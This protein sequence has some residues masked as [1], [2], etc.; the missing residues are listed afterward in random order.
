MKEK[1]VEITEET[2]SFNKEISVSDLVFNY[3]SSPIDLG[4]FCIKKGEYIGF[5]GYSGIG[6]T[7][8]FN[9]LL[10]FLKPTEGEIRIDGKLLDGN[11]RKSWLEHIGY[12]PQEIYIFNGTIAENVALCS[13]IPDMDKVIEVLEKV[14]LK[15]WAL[16]LP[17][18]ADT[19][20]G[21]GGNNLSGG[22]K[23]RLAI[24]RILLKGNKVLV[25]DEATSALDN[26]SQSKIVK[27][28]DNLKKDHTVVV[29][30]H[31]LSTIVD[32]DHILLVE[33]GKVVA[34]GTH[35]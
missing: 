28:L 35:S 9:L 30:A 2:I 12:V 19:I 15:D 23:Q 14:K 17:D 3:G 18:K 13:Q 25:F 8:L 27:E 24:A 29:V 4:S 11:S 22:Q 10:G 1:A 5:K 32:A 16:S 31:R 21:E 33:D 7:T 34:E 26:A 20:L 6:K